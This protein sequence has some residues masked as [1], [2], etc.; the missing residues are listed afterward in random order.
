MTLS[1]PAALAYVVIKG[2]TL[3]VAVFDVDVEDVLLVGL[4]ALV[5]LTRTNDEL[6]K[7]AQ[8]CTGGDAMTAD[9]VLLHTL[10]T[11]LLATDGSLVEHLGGLLE[12]SGR[13]EALGTEG[14]TGDTLEY[15]SGCGLDS[16]AHLDE[17]QVAALEA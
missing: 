9:N 1:G 7:L 4:D 11:V 13:H 6:V 10:E 8:T 2:K 5:I 17:A 15:L 3:D 14:S 12:R 16:I